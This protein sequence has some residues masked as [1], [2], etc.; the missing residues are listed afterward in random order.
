MIRH[1]FPLLV[2]SYQLT[3][4]TLSLPTILNLT[5]DSMLL[6]ATEDPEAHCTP[7]DE[8]TQHR[9]PI[10]SDC[11]RAVRALPSSDYV[12]YFHLGGDASLWRLP[13]VPTYGSC[14]ALV[15][16]HQDIDQ[17]L[18]SWDD[19][20]RS[21]ASLLI[22]CRKEYAPGGVQRTGGWIT[23]G[24]EN[25]IVIEL[26]MPQTITVNGMGTG[27]GQETSAVEVQ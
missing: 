2:I 4:F 21:A 22:T 6:N 1:M 14:K 11:I 19:I 23:A 10:V 25:G 24:A 26:A 15:N 12:G 27:T 16:L 20:R 8:S 3:I 18:G 13:V 7:A 9:L 5:A 17:E